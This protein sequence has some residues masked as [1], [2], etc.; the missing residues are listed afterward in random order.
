MSQRQ[1]HSPLGTVSSRPEFRAFMPPSTRHDDALDDA[2]A[3]LALV[4]A[5]EGFDLGEET[6]FLAWEL[7]RMQ[8]GLEG[9]ERRAALVLTLATLVASRQGSTCTPRDALPGLIAACIPDALQMTPGWHPETLARDALAMLDG[10]KLRAI[11]GEPGQYRPLIMDEGALYHQRALSQEQ[12]LVDALA[13][14][15]LQQQTSIDTSR[16]GQALAAVLS[17][18]PAGP[19]GVPLVLTDEQQRAAIACATQ[20]MTLIT[21][22]P[23]TGKTAVI[24]SVLRLLARLGV[25]PEA[26]ALSAPT[27]KAANR[28]QEALLL[29]LDALTDADPLDLALASKL[30]RPQ[31]IHRL[32]GY[33]P[34][35][36]E[37]QHHEHHPLPA[38]VVVVDE[39][40]MIDLTLMD[41]LLRA[42]R[43]DAHLILLGDADQLPSVE[44]GAVFR[45]LIRASADAVAR[46]SIS[47]RMREDDPTGRHILCVARRVRAGDPTP[48]LV[49]RGW[50]GAELEQGRPAQPLDAASLGGVAWIDGAA[51][52]LDPATTHERLR[53]VITWWFEQLVTP[54]EGFEALARA[55]LSG[56]D[57]DVFTDTSA[58]A[59]LR[60]LFERAQRARL[61][62]ITRARVSGV[63][64]LNA[65]CLDLLRARLGARQHEV[66]LPGAPVMMTRNDYVRELFNGDQGLI[67]PVWSDGRPTRMA[68]F[69]RGDTFRAFPVEGLRA[70]LELAFAMTVHKS[71][72]SEFDHVA[73]VLP[74]EPLPLLT[75]EVLY[76]AITRSRASVTLIGDP[77][78]F[79]AG[80]SAS[81]ARHGRIAQRYGATL[82]ALRASRAQADAEA[83]AEASVSAAGD[84][85][86][87]P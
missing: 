19:R 82:D 76:T 62:A 57:G 87:A 28:M 81:M 60:A 22:G 24:V 72:G 79:A 33:L 11:V 38:Q 1:R 10:G 29:Q 13:A 6:C 44:A 16:L 17:A 34:H 67:L 26:M 5:L 84:V 56:F 18:P 80:V 2:Q 48:E 73:L 27:G 65:A 59:R 23:G 83:E 69:P 12:R 63:D 46:L 15:A 3:V 14:R 35:S 9:P 21:G 49:A 51:P 4:E 52:G 71:Q 86:A 43:P 36:E 70:R 61:L 64:A 37:F 31:T 30:P 55:P 8:P 7:V 75:R 45:D 42:V 78:L 74:G 20:P 39:A 66:F 53:Q 25:A 47:Q 32:L 50:V 58:I 41:R 85:E 68:V 54:P 40:S 77:R